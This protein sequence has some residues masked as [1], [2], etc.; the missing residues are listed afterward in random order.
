MSEKE[1][2]DISKLL[3]DILQRITRME[4][5]LDDYKEL[6]S[7][8]DAIDTKVTTIENNMGGK[9]EKYKAK[10]AFYGSIITAIGLVVVAIIQ[11]LSK[12]V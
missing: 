4:E 10:F 1:I 5:K 2:G 11:Y 6:K 12:G 9:V 7:K 3:M 8:V